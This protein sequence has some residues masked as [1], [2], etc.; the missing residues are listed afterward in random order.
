[1]DSEDES[2]SDGLLQLC[3]GGVDQRVD[4]AA[5]ATRGRPRLPARSIRSAQ[6]QVRRL[7]SRESSSRVVA[8][9]AVDDQQA[10][11][12]ETVQAMDAV[13]FC[14]EDGQITYKTAMRVAQA[15]CHLGMCTIQKCLFGE[16]LGLTAINGLRVRIAQCL[17]TMHQLR[18]GLRTEAWVC[19]VA[20][21][22]GWAP[23]R[24]L[25]PGGGELR[26]EGQMIEG[27]F[28]L[29]D[30]PAEALVL[31]DDAGAPSEDCAAVAGVMWKWDGKAIPA[32]VKERVSAEG[33]GADV[34]GLGDTWV[35]GQGAEC[36]VQR[37]CLVTCPWRGKPDKLPI[38]VPPKA[39]G[40]KSG[41]GILAAIEVRAAVS[42]VVDTLQGIALTTG[43]A[44]PALLIC[45][46]I[47]VVLCFCVDA[48]S[49]NLT[50]IREAMK[51][52]DHLNRTNVVG[53]VVLVVTRLCLAH[54]VHLCGRSIFPVSVLA[55]VLADPSKGLSKSATFSVMLHT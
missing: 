48:A 28:A 29:E 11:L 46:M 2:D 20:S 6:Q 55:V 8:R 5:P 47:A 1:M 34:T 40:D 35:G 41:L 30:R 10:G 49:A 39:L 17:R 13:L 33:L 15:P 53:I 50:A 31:A 52:Y 4:C 21:A 25:R 18:M 12:R 23:P 7:A 22:S 54:Q 9:R 32:H 14:K 27:F 16:G 43:V 42:K 36:L 45:P 37:G 19:S 44:R 3:V 26:A 38:P 51:I 24:A